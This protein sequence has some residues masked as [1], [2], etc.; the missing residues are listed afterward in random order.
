MDTPTPAPFGKAWLNSWLEAHQDGTV[1]RKL[2]DACPPSNPTVPSTFLN[3]TL[4]TPNRT[5][6][7]I[8]LLI[9]PMSCQ[10]FASSNWILYHHLCRISHRQLLLNHHH[11]AQCR[12][13][14][15]SLL[16][17]TRYL[18]SP[19]CKIQSPSLRVGRQIL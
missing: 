19:P 1:S 18:C 3:S 17:V 6:K 8:K 14:R 5:G 13:V 10:S 15:C 2:T 11:S 7:M 4:G 16:A 9:L 12:S